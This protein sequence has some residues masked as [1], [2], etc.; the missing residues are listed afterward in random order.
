MNTKRRKSTV[1]VKDVA[2]E[3]GLSLSTVI[4]ILGGREQRY[5]DETCRRVNETAQRMGYRRNSSARAMRSGKFDCVALLMSAEPD[6]TLMRQP[7]LEGI[8]DELA[9]HGMH[10]NVAR[11]P[12]EALADEG[13][14]PKLLREWTADGLLV[15]FAMHIP[16]SMVE[17]IE[18][19]NLP[20]VWMRSKRD[21]DCVYLD[22]KDAARQAVDHLAGLGHRR[23]AFA[24][25]TCGTMSLASSHHGLL[26]FEAGFREQMKKA[27]LTPQVVREEDRVDRSDRTARFRAIFSRKDRPTALIAMPSTALPAVTAAVGAGLRI[28]EDLSII[29]MSDEI[30]DSTGIAL[31]T[32]ITPEYDIGRRS[33]ALVVK[34]IKEPG[35]PLP[36]CLVKF[37]LTD[38]GSCAPPPKRER[39][40]TATRS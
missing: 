23:I 3:S 29:T 31:T 21:C 24:D 16:P 1:T 18:S 15:A 25:Y 4:H 9:L 26:D 30:Q 34:R 8:C 19:S 12:S 33:A 7:A 28:P 38:A 36:P 27:G 11:L 37:I 5:R 10:L 17:R 39:S 20:C 6:A 22:E 2:R 13:L 14:V 35:R 40:T 32:L